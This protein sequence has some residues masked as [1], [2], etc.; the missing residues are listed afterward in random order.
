MSVTLHLAHLAAVSLRLACSGVGWAGGPVFGLEGVGATPIQGEPRQGEPG[1]QEEVRGVRGLRPAHWLGAN[2][3]RDPSRK[4]GPFAALTVT[5][6]LVCG[7]CSRT[8]AV[9][10]TVSCQ[11]SLQCQE[12]EPSCSS[13]PLVPQYPNCGWEEA[14][15][16]VPAGP[17]GWY[18]M[19]RGP[20]GS[21]EEAGQVYSPGQGGPL[22]GLLPEPPVLQGVLDEQSG[23]GGLS[24]LSHGMR[25][26][27]ITLEQ[28]GPE[29]S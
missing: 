16:I 7:F 24:S 1:A 25:P 6:V 3:D 8:Q 19:L 27:G 23:L 4:A 29:A 28:E 15:E 26:Q 5:W 10:Q 12:G 22:P 2:K 21:L 9:R 11:S 18:E 13:L 17:Q 14:L 20:P